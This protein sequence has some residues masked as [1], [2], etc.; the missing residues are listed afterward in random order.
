MASELRV[1]AK[2]SDS[3]AS[4]LR[5]FIPRASPDSKQQIISAVQNHACE[6]ASGQLLALWVNAGFRDQCCRRES[7]VLNKAPTRALKSAQGSTDWRRGGR[8]EAGT[9]FLA[10]LLGHCCCGAGW[11]PSLSPH[12]FTMLWEQDWG[13]GGE[14]ANRSCSQ[15]EVEE[16][17]FMKLA[18]LIESIVLST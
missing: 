5:L 8:G 11:A 3:R 17:G 1:G 14:A 15:G 18:E 7:H 16:E 2:G 12:S 10:L 6:A 9:C 13:R 4:L